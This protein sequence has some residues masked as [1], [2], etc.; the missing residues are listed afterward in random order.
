MNGELMAVLKD[1]DLLDLLKKHLPATLQEK[2]SLDERFKMSVRSIQTPRYIIPVFGVQGSGKSSLLNALLFEDIILPVDADETTCIPTEI[3]Y[4]DYEL[5]QAQVVFKNGQREIIACSEI[6]L[7]AFVHQA[8]NPDNKKDVDRILITMRHPLLKSGLVLVDLPGV[9]SITTANTN[10]TMSY[11]KETTGAIFLLRTVPPI[12]K[13]EAV[14]IQGIWPLMSNTFFIQNQWSDERIEEV[15]EGREHSLSVLKKIAESCKIPKDNLNIDIVNIDLSLKARIRKDETIPSKSGLPNFTEKLQIFAENWQQNVQNQIKNNLIELIKASQNE[16]NYR[17]ELNQKSAADHERE[18]ESARQE[19]EKELSDKKKSVSSCFEFMGKQKEKLNKIITEICRV[20][21]ENF[22]NA[23]RDVINEGVTGGSQL[24]QAFMDHHKEQLDEIFG[25]IQPD[26]IGV[27]QEIIERIDAIGS[28]S[29][30]KIEVQQNANFN[31]QTNIHSIYQPVGT[32]TIGVGGM[33]GGAVLGTIIFPGIGTVIG[34]AIGGI[35]GGLL[36]GWLCGKAK[37]YHLDQQRDTAKEQLFKMIENFKQE[38]IK[39]YKKNLADYCEEI[40][41]AINQ[42][43]LSKENEYKDRE[44]SIKAD[45]SKSDEE[46]QVIHIE[47]NNDLGALEK[48]ITLLN[49]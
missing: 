32:S 11:I 18:L 30:N 37:D 27:T 42:W 12:V 22:R 4:S 46:K 25:K 43:I 23:M 24:N 35:L 7:K 34:G 3:S 21:S 8:D 5:P 19:F 20:S 33:Y 26:I 38:T 41:K 2:I 13:S 36:G 49:N 10:T 29:F 16:I 15:E 47:L 40:E 1:N 39:G 45:A 31:K 9:G 14:F 28:F 17:L 6:G 48:Y 44:D